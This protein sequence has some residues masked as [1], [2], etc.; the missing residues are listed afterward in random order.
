MKDIVFDL[1]GVL[2]DWNPR[3]LYNKIFATEAET[4]WFLANVCTSQWNTQQDAGR[5]FAEGIE[6]L[7]TKYP[8][9]T[10]AIEF[11]LSR[12]EEMLKGAIEGSVDILRKL[13]TRGYRTYALSNWSMETFP[14]VQ[15]KYGFFNAFDGM[16]I[17]GQEKLVKPDPK[18]YTR[19]L[20]RYDLHADNCIF[21]DDNAANIK[22][23]QALGFGTILFTSPENLRAELCQRGVL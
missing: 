22:G 19:L 10:F 16:V 15:K 21:I 6:L 14:L 7:K 23:A 8:E 1:G 3:H 5:P 9:Y 17:S 12:W 13:K 4:E 20:K 2:I 11:Y 18:I